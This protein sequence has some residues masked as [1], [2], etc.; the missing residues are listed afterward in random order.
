MSKKIEVLVVD[1]SAYMRKVITNMLQSDEEIFV[2]DTARDGLDALEKVKKWKPHV[3]TLDVEMPRMDGLTALQKIM[4]ECPTA[5]IMLSSLTQEGNETTIKAL[6][7]GAVDFVPKPSG[8]ISLDIAKVREDLIAKI[9]VCSRA[10]LK[11]VRNIVH[12]PAGK[13]IRPQV[14]VPVGGLPD[15]LVIIGSSTGGPNALQQ[16]V[17]RLPGN[18]PA[19]V[20]IVQHMPAGFTHSLAVRL[21]DIS[22]LQVK[23]A[24][25][26]DKLQIG[27]VYIAPGGQHMVLEGNKIRLNTNPPVHSVRPAVDVTME[28]V[29]QNFRGALVGVVLTGMGYDGAKG[30]V[31]I[32]KVGGKTIA[33][34]EAT[35]VV[36]GMPRVV[37]EMG[38]ADKVLPITEIAEEIVNML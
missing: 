15:K 11:N 22:N 6:T 30:M 20:L 7:L 35:C 27:Q 33:Q 28:S 17:P 21:N 23:E 32:K 3:V 8:A 34:N 26:G 31:A 13:I 29:V 12:P 19:G 16:V 38:K 24:A 18:L 5:V 14:A 36:Y 4:Q 10:V 2:V 9:K 25:E 1:D 37:V